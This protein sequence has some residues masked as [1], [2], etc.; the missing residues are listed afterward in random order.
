VANRD[1]VAQQTQAEAGKRPPVSLITGT[2]PVQ[3][4][5]TNLIYWAYNN[6]DSSSLLE[7]LATREVMR[8]LAGAD[9]N[10]LLSHG[11]GRGAEALRPF[12]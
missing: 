3:F 8:Y 4:Q 1:T 5:I 11:R 7:D 12:C 10:D 6:E 9:M 2:I